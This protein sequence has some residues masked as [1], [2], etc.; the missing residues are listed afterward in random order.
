S[1]ALV[2]LNVAATRPAATQI[3]TREI[4]VGQLDLEYVVAPRLAL[5]AHADS[6]S[7]W[8]TVDRD[9]VIDDPAISVIRINC[10]SGDRGLFYVHAVPMVDVVEVPPERAVLDA[11][12]DTEVALGARRCAGNPAAARHEVARWRLSRWIG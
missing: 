11:A 7:A 9:V 2:E 3:A 12:G 6:G 5:I 4:A 10:V 1:L 8:L